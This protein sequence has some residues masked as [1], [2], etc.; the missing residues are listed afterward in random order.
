MPIVSVAVGKVAHFIDPKQAFERRIDKGLPH[1][2]PDQR[3][4]KMGHRIQ[5]PGRRRTFVVLR[6]PV[7][8]DDGEPDRWHFDHGE[9]IRRRQ[10]EVSQSIVKV[11]YIHFG[12]S[13]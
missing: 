7:A 4:D 3:L 11:V 12:V 5:P 8:V 1:A 2:L 13:V 6:V 10:V 9:P